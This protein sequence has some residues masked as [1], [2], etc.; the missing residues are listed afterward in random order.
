MINEEGI[1]MPNIFDVLSRHWD[2]SEDDEPYPEDPE[3]FLKQVV[4]ENKDLFQEEK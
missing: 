3:E 4:E 1:L 2:E